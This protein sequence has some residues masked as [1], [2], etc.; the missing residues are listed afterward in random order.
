[1]VR[2]SAPEASTVFSGGMPVDALPHDEG[3][4]HHASVTVCVGPDREEEFRTEL[5][6]E[7][8]SALGMNHA[9]PFLYIEFRE[10]DPG[11]VYLAHRGTLRRAGEALAAAE[12]KAHR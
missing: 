7:I 5:A 1:M 6:G 10:T 3:G 4:L 11:D 9:T 12:R 2:F 8:A